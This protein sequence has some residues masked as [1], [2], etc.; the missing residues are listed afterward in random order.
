M[1]NLLLLIFVSF[2]VIASVGQTFKKPTVAIQPGSEEGVTRM[3]PPGLMNNHANPV[4]DLLQTWAL[5]SDGSYSVNTRIPGNTYKY[6]RTEYLIT[7]SEMAASGFPAGNTIDGIGFLIYQ[8][9][10]TSQT[11][12]FKVYLMN[13]NDES[14]SLGSTWTTA[15]FTEASNIA[16]WTVP[17]A[18]G[19]YT[20]SFSGGTPF[21][22]SG[23]GVYV[24]WEFSN[25]GGG[26]GTTALYA[27]CNTS[28]TGGLYGARSSSS[29]P[30]TLA[31]SDYRPATIF[32]NN[33]LNDIV[34]ITN[35]YTLERAP[36]PFGAPLHETVRVE[37]V[38]TAAATFD[39]TLTVKDAMGT[40]TRY[41]GT[42]TVTNLAGSTST[43]VDF[44][45]TPTIQED[46]IIIATASAPEGENFTIN[47]TLTIPGNINDYLFSYNYYTDGAGGFG[48][49]YPENGMF[50]SKFHMN[51]SG[52]VYGS[53][54]VIYNNSANV[55][56]TVVIALMDAGGNILTQSPQYI[57]QNADLGNNVNFAFETPQVF[58]N[59]DFLIG[60]IQNIG[61]EQWYP[62]GT[63]NENPL[64]SGIFYYANIDGSSLTELPTSYGLKYGI[65]AQVSVPTTTVNPSAF[66]AT[67]VSTSQIDLSWLLN[68]SGNDV[69]LAWSADG[70]FGT[71]E[72][73]TTYSAGNS[74]PGGGTVLQFSN[75]TSYSHTGLTPGTVYYYKAWSYHGTSYSPGVSTYAAT[76][77]NPSVLP[78]NEDFSA[79][80]VS[81]CW[82][83]SST[84][85]D[86]WYL[87]N[88]NYAGGAPNEM[89][90][91]WTNAIGVTR[92][93][94]PP[95]NT[96]GMTELVLD[97]RQFFDDYDSGLVYK[98]QSSAD[99]ITWTDEAWLNYSGN[100]NTGPGMVN[101]SIVNNLGGTT[102]IAF[103]L[104]GDHYQ[105]D[106]WFI[107]DI[108]ISEFIPAN[109]AL[110]LKLF[111]EGLYDGA[112]GLIEARDEVGPHWGTGIADKVTIEL[113]DGTTGATVTTLSNLDLSTSGN[114]STTVPASYN[115]SYYIYVIHRNSITT[116]SAG[117]VNF[118]L[119]L[120][121]TGGTISYDFTT[122][123]AQAFG[124]NMKDAGGIAL[125]YAGDVNQ[126]YNVDASDMIDVDND[127]AAFA[128]GYLLTDVNGD[129]NVDAS[130]MIIVDN[131]NAAFVAAILPF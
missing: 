85:G 103:V 6:Q 97:F 76:I 117:P 118:A 56:D 9:G 35:I 108:S 86:S 116:S 60:L 111:L 26:A 24:A 131:N 51:G 88:S 120:S 129:G 64:R 115:G 62:L 106:N 17:I 42:Q 20:V 33:T 61:S 130:D 113:R 25:T 37:N 55:G 58:T 123:I 68:P 15:G 112:G 23:G 53:N 36:I 93:I 22:Y 121:T 3:S 39:V 77:C 84:I 126:D 45:W 50:A 67:P 122:G 7:A 1:K 63:F 74:I 70:T 4:T 49:T 83:E 82:T 40:S 57:I 127:N 72:E 114:I 94:L 18:A 54:V 65:E 34:S 91:Q 47:N 110:N 13:T 102:W 5:P 71:P 90:V 95:L 75:A 21:T 44:T 29:L 14:Y 48:F 59:E 69:L 78:F 79:S 2:A 96:T 101:T 12:T 87:V 81:I 10:G 11:G 100:G 38:N 119:P 109:T 8:A 105:F 19:A 73:G 80:T 28:L 98:V 124:S 107:D 125:I 99:G 43:L 30:T 52:S 32:F 128:S 89:W 16:S 92:L 104:D 27:N 66:T 31:V 46:I 41:S